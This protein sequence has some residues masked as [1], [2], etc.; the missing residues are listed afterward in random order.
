[1]ACIPKSC[2][3]CFSVSTGSKI[4]GIFAII[5]LFAEIEQFYPLRLAANGL[6]AV[7]FVLML[8]DDS[9]FKRKL[10]FY[11]F[12]LSGLFQYVFGVYN[13]FT[14]TD[15]KQPWIQACD[16]INRK[17]ELANIHATSLEECH[18]SIEN[19]IHTVLTVMFIAYGL[20]QIHFLLVVY[21]HWKNHEDDHVNDVA[22]RKL[23]DETSK[24]DTVL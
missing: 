14:L 4:L 10:F 7:S 3:C 13:A 20:L 16:D 19:M 22:M 21:T 5:G 15:A 18:E 1:M 6:C 24:N 12:V 23:E 2:C 11:C 9:E 17:G 8:L